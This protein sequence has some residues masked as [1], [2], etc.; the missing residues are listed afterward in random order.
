MLSTRY[1]SS[2]RI[3]VSKTIY[4]SH[5]VMFHL[6]ECVTHPLKKGISF[7]KNSVVLLT[8]EKQT[9][10]IPIVLRLKL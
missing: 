3:G 8:Y 2:Q 4:A 1:I 10:Q 6:L 9:E 5:V 7:K